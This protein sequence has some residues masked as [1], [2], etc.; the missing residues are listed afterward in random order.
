M[1]GVK[2]KVIPYSG[3]SAVLVAAV[4]GEVSGSL[5]VPS[6]TK[7]NIEGGTLKALAIASPKEMSV[8]PGMKTVA[9]YGFPGFSSGTWYALFGPKDM[10]KELTAKIN[11]ASRKALTAPEVKGK[12]LTNGA[13]ATGTKSPEEFAQY[14]KEEG[15]KYGEI[16]SK[17]NL[18]VAAQK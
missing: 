17:L 5:M 9:S 13:E 4:S 11:Q 7:A 6:V 16:I 14:V 15:K 2:A 18:A 1:A 8:M 12:L 10:P 3:Q